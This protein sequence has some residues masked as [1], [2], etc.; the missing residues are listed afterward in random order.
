MDDLWTKAKTWI[1]ENKMLSIVAGIVAVALIV[2]VVAV[3]RAA[4]APTDQYGFEKHVGRTI[5]ISFVC[6]DAASATTVA[7]I[8]AENLHLREMGVPTEEADAVFK[9]ILDTGA[10]IILP[11]A[12]PVR[13]VKVLSIHVGQ[14]K[15]FAVWHGRA[16][17]QDVYV[18]GALNKKT[19]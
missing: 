8:L 11:G 2:G 4:P 6:K 3:A 7:K 19:P 10:C 13:L 17:A 16:G 14:D 12:L 5:G 9:K 1:S 15:V 18:I